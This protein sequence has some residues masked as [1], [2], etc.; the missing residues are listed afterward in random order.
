M[1][2]AHEGESEGLASV[3]TTRA[4]RGFHWECLDEY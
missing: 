2:F 4:S 3:D 1:I